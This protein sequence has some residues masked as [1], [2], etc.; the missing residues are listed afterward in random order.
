MLYCV[1]SSFCLP[2]GVAVCFRRR[3]VLSLRLVFVAFFAAN[4]EAASA[5][6][7]A[8]RDDIN[9]KTVDTEAR[10]GRL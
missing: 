8:D 2:A 7:G 1:S 6:N 10:E 4:V 3:C 5:M 9:F